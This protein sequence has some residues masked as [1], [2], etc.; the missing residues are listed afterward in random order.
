MEKQYGE[1]KI[2]YFQVIIIMHCYN[3][4]T[5]I[6]YYELPY[7][8]IYDF[9]VLLFTYSFIHLLFTHLLIV[10]SQHTLPPILGISKIFNVFFTGVSSAHQGC[11]Y[12]IKNTEKNSNIVKFYCNFEY[13]FPILIYLHLHHFADALIQSDLQ[14]L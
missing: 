1:W 7:D 6:M 14:L 3:F 8:V 9:W 5:D 11:I 2:K 10:Y 4:H 13:W 12:S